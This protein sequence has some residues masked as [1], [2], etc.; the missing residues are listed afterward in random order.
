M[1]TDGY[2]SMNVCSMNLSAGNSFENFRL[3]LSKESLYIVLDFLKDS[4]WFFNTE[5][6]SS[7]RNSSNDT[8]RKSLYISKS[9]NT[10]FFF[11]SS[12]GMEKLYLDWYVLLPISKAERHMSGKFS[13]L[14]RKLP[15]NELYS[16]SCS[17]CSMWYKSQRFF[18]LLTK[19]FL[20]HRLLH[21]ALNF[22]PRFLTSLLIF[23]CS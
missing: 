1:L 21:K 10:M 15:M 2:V 12:F 19:S 16:G 3:N 7:M 6:V 9:G 22:F 18:K 8:A 23:N 4:Y 5:N 11:L 17:L 13:F 14:N 20:H